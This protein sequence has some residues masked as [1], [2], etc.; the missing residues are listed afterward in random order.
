MIELES[1]VSHQLGRVGAVKRIQEFVGSLPQR[2]PEQVHQ[3]TMQA[4]ENAVEV[5]FA[6]YGY[7]LQ[8]KAEVYDTCI[9]LHGTI[10]DAA[11]KFKEKMMQTVVDR[12]SDAVRPVT[13]PLRRAA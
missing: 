10:P 7:V 3:V 11:R 2:F 9:V 8:W 1:S 4:Y 12:I 5:R 6:A 13:L